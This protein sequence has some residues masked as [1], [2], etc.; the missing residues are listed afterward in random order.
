LKKAVRELNLDLKKSLFVG[1][2]LKDIQAG[3]RAGCRILLVQTGQ[4]KGSLIK[5]LSGKTRIKPDWVCDDLSPVTPL[6]FGLLA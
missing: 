3:Q 1:D 6:Y 5:I 2:S 4:G